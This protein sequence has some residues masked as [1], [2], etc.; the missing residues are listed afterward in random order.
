LKKSSTAIIL[1]HVTFFKIFV[2][3]SAVNAEKSNGATGSAKN[4]I[5][6]HLKGGCL[7]YFAP[8][9]YA[10]STSV[11]EQRSIASSMLI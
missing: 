4:V 3:V 6:S 10:Q 5:G 11:D 2:A 7:V 8:L 1:A 9:R